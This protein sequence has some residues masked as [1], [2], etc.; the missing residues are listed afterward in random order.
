MLRIYVFNFRKIV[1]DLFF[2]WLDYN[3]YVAILYPDEND[4]NNT[5][6]WRNKMHWETIGNKTLEKI[7]WNQIKSHE[8]QSKNIIKNLQFP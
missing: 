5:R 1:S 4:K 8:W 6:I 3:V 7:V 2:Q